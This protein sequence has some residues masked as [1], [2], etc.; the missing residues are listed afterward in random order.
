MSKIISSQKIGFIV[1]LL[2]AAVMHSQAQNYKAYNNYDFIPGN[3]I[4]FE[5]DFRSD[6]DGEFPAHWKLVGGQA[7][8][9][10]KDNER[11]V[12]ITKYYTILSPNIKTAGKGKSYVPNEYTIEFDAWLD[13]AYDSNRGVGLRFM[14][15]GE[16][17]AN[18]ETSNSEIACSFPGGR[19]QGDMPREYA[20]EA[21]HNKWHHFAIAVKD[22][23]LKVYM[24]QYR[25][26]V[27]PDANFKASGIAIAGD[28]SDGMAMLFRNFRF[29]EGGGMNMVGKKFTDTKIITHGINFDYHKASIKPESM[30]TLNAI[31]QIMKD[32]PDIKFEVGGHTDGDGDAAYN[33]K[34]SQ[35]RADAVKQQLVKMGI[36]VSRLTTKGYGKTKPLA[37]ETTPEAKA[38]NR[39]VEFV[40]L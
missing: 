22:K 32:N 1:T 25:V 12:A 24:D 11:V 10:N 37:A 36:D 35:Q 9:N 6:Q 31:V 30:G 13:G 14:S 29:A 3:R 26:L 34:L 21:F 16:A 8:V 17:V 4:I 18:I 40:K 19:L 27:V 7:V 39:R 38:N 2:L 5:D 15:G 20:N 28:A 23:Q 33:L